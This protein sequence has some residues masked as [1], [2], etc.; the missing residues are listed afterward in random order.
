ML[1]TL[2]TGLNF[3][4]YVFVNR[5]QEFKAAIATQ[6]L[7]TAGILKD[8][9]LR[10]WFDDNE[11]YGPLYESIQA[12]YPWGRHDLTYLLPVAAAD[13]LP[14]LV[15][16]DAAVIHLTTVPAK[17]EERGRLLAARNIKVQEIGHWT[18][19][20]GDIEFEVFVQRVL[21]ASDLK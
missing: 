7:L 16:P 6:N 14:D 2:S 4:S 1:V 12:L 20:R 15:P 3:S 5:R 9:P 17:M 10:F 13:K 18:I 8:R 19:Q 21:S 11:R